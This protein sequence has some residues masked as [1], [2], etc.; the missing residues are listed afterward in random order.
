MS[1]NNKLAALNKFRNV[2]ANVLRS[3]PTKIL[4]VYDVQV[5]TPEVSQIPLIVNYG[6]GPIPLTFVSDWLTDTSLRSSKS[7]R[8]VCASV[9]ASVFSHDRSGLILL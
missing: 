3:T 2:G 7:C 4:V 8:G 1:S 6:D 5:K 9:G